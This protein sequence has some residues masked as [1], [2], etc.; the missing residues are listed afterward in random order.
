MRARFS[1]LVMA[2]MLGPSASVFAL[3]S[4]R[5]QPIEINADRAELDEGKGV[6]HY[7]GNVELTQGSLLIRADDLII[8]ADDKNQLQ[9]VTAQ[10]KPA[11]FNQTPE[12]GKP[13][14]VAKAKT[15]DYFVAD[16]KLMLQLDAIVVQNDSTFQGTQ[17]Q[18]DIRNR[19]MQASSTANTGP[20]SQRVKMVLPP[21][22]TPENGSNGTAAPNTEAHQGKTTPAAAPTKTGGQKP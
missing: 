11:E 14:V 6:A 18:Y 2:G 1:V 8:Q 9:R 22:A 5:Q 13:P 12:A 21:N 16:E 20:K 3:E 19:R 15:I 10:G 17:I 4:D 7:I